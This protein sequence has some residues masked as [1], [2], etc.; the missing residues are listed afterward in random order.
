MKYSTRL[1]L[2]VLSAV[3]I[4]STVYPCEASYSLVRALECVESGYNTNAI[5]DGGKAVGCLQIWTIVVDDC[6]RIEGKKRFSYEDRHDRTK[7]YQMAR[8]YLEYWGTKYEARTGRKATNEI[9][10]RIWNGGPNGWKN[11]NTKIYWKKVNN[12]LRR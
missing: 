5:G 12:K 10:A 2:A 9:L 3:G 11:T 8:I 1:F 4:Q 7:S 6:N